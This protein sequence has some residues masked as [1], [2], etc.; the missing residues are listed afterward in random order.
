MIPRP[1]FPRAR[2]E[3]PGRQG[4]APPE[5]AARGPNA[6]REA[7]A[8]ILTLMPGASRPLAITRYSTPLPERHYATHW[9]GTLSRGQVGTVAKPPPRFEPRGRRLWPGGRDSSGSRLALLPAYPS[10]T[11]KGRR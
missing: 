8:A 2:A 3:R 9:C 1:V 5:T 11:R 4:S 6:H 10:R 7:P